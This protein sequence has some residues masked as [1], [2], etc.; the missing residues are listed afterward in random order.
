MVQ[1]LLDQ[2]KGVITN[3]RCEGD[4]KLLIQGESELGGMAREQK[5]SL[6]G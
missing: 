1:S 5:R 2:I 6:A 3:T 4:I